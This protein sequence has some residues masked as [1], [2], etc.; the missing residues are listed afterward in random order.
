MD[1]VAISYTTIEKQLPKANVG[2]PI[3]LFSIHSNPSPF[4]YNIISQNLQGKRSGMFL[5]NA[6][7]ILQSLLVVEKFEFEFKR[8]IQE[9]IFIPK[10]SGG[11]GLPRTYPGIEILKESLRRM[12]FHLI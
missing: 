4:N 2:I 6:T 11:F 12:T 3:S 1:H 8:A 5:D 10:P 9:N 7:Q